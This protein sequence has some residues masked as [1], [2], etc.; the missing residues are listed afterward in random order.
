MKPYPLTGPRTGPRPPS[1]LYVV[2]DR[3]RLSKDKRSLVVNDGLTLEGIPPDAFQYRLGN[4]SALDWVID[5]YQL[6]RDKTTGEITSNPNRD[7]D[8]EYIVRLVKQIITLS[9]ETTRIIAGL[10]GF[11]LKEEHVRNV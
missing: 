5:Q 9:L 2:D 7:D 6:E 4:R 11:D 8:P 3:M 10:P 1:Q